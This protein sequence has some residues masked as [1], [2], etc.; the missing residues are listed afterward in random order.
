MLWG[1]GGFARGGG[2]RCV[3]RGVCWWKGR[4][5]VDFEGTCDLGGRRLEVVMCVFGRLVCLRVGLAVL[6]GVV[7][8]GG[9]G[10]GE[11]REGCVWGD[12]CIYV[13]A[14]VVEG[15]WNRRGGGRG[16]CERRLGDGVAGD[17]S[18]KTDR[19]AARDERGRT[20]ARRGMKMD[21]QRRGA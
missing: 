16:G 11:R 18:K 4:R 9:F 21:G 2:L 8:Q 13:C 14:R 1:E 3:G 7:V 5:S 12:A 15:A 10:R 20:D 6:M 17:G 19:R